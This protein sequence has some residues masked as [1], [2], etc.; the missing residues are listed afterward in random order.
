MLDWLPE[1]DF[2]HL[3][4][5]VDGIVASDNYVPVLPGEPSAVIPPRLT[6]FEAGVHLVLG[7][8]DLEAVRRDIEGPIL[9]AWVL[10]DAPPESG[11]SVVPRPVE[12]TPYSDG[13]HLMYAIQ[14]FGFAA[15]AVAGAIVFLL[16]PGRESQE[17]SSP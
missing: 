16:S 8:L 5:P 7:S 9:N 15:I 2:V 10:P 1:T 12:P 6:R 13:P 11:A 4:L 17:R 3:V 14:W